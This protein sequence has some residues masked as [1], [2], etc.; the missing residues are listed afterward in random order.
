MFQVANLDFIPNPVEDLFSD[1][2]KN[3]FEV[4]GKYAIIGTEGLFVIT[5][6]P[7]LMT[8]G[9]YVLFY[10]FALLIK[11]CLPMDYKRLHKNLLKIVGWYEWSGLIG[12][13]IASY[14]DIVQDAFL[15]VRVLSFSSALF[16]VSSVLSI[17]FTIFGVAMP[18]LAAFIVYKNGHNLR[19]LKKKYEILVDRCNIESSMPRYVTAISLLRA[20]IVN[21][22]LVFLQ[23]YPIVQTSL[24]TASNAIIVLI[25]IFKRNI[26]KSVLDKFVRILQELFFTILYLTTLILS[27]VTFSEG[28]TLNI[29]WIFIGCCMIIFLVFLL[30]SLYENFIIIKQFIRNF[31]RPPPKRQTPAKRRKQRIQELSDIT[32]DDVSMSIS[33]TKATLNLTTS[34]EAPPDP[35]RPSKAKLIR[36]SDHPQ[37]NRSRSRTEENIEI[38]STINKPQ[39]GMNERRPRAVTNVTDGDKLRTKRSNSKHENHK[40]AKKK[41]ESSAGVPITNMNP[42][43]RSQ[44]HNYK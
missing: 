13:L 41:K 37:Q 28:A 11:K 17:I 33:N 22:A 32:V 23:D 27:L 18:F 24:L 3:T 42:I 39:T 40:I 26:F 20:L 43:F 2:E 34:Y 44:K 38:R 10:L 9:V 35:I 29:G 4:P 31:R 19:H 8:W 21:A 14:P 36:N 5:S 6:C 25:Y 12:I 15:E 7:I 16:S 1:V 30:S